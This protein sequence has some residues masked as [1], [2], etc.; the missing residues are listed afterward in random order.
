MVASD[1]DSTPILQM[2]DLRNAHSPA[3]VLQ[4]HSRGILGMSWCD[5]DTS[6]LLTCG[7]DNRTLCWNP[8]TGQVRLCLPR[9]TPCARGSAEGDW[10]EGFAAV[11]RSWGLW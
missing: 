11:W 9:T 3:K 6:M 8:N 1:D 7:K 4:G 5:F 10:R 2:W